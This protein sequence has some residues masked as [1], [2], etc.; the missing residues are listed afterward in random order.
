M[1]IV[2]K[3]SYIASLATPNWEFGPGRISGVSFN[4]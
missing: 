3:R 2:A 1:Y 4:R